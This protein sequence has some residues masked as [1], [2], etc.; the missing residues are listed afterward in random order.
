MD[1]QNKSEENRRSGI[2][3]ANST[4]QSLNSDAAD[5]VGMPDEQDYEVL[6]GIFRSFERKNPGLIQATVKRGRMEYEMG[7]N[8]LKKTFDPNQRA[9]T[10]TDSNMEY[11][12][13]LPAGLVARIEKTFP[14][15]FRSKKHFGWFKKNFY[16]LTISGNSK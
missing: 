15:M 3:D 9:I 5:A 4:F 14:T 1:K 13:E 2:L 6:A 12:F 10:S 11:V 16:K 7:S 8:R